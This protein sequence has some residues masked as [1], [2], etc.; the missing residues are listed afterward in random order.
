MFTFTAPISHAL[1]FLRY[2]TTTVYRS[3][4]LL[5]ALSSALTLFL[6]LFR[7]SFLRL[8]GHDVLKLRPKRLDRGELIAN[9]YLRVRWGVYV[10]CVST[11][12]YRNDGLQR[13]VQLVDVCE[14][15]FNTLSP[16]AT[17]ENRGSISQHSGFIC[18]LVVR[19]DGGGSGFRMPWWGFSADTGDD[20]DEEL[21]SQ[22]L[23][24][25]LLTMAISPI[26]SSRCCSK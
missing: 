22:V 20:D 14:D 9:L 19:W 15:M 7:L 26:S 2:E 18:C 4:C 21:T 3:P 17:G 6:L 11:R 24:P 16:T 10:S 13:P 8:F 5:I 1:L 23:F 12:T 25:C